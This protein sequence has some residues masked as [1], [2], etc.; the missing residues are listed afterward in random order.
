[1]GVG[2]WSA[3]WAGDQDS[4][5]TIIHEVGSA[6]ATAEAW[7]ELEAAE[8]ATVLHATLSSAKQ[9]VEVRGPK[10]ERSLWHVTIEWAPFCMAIPA[11]GG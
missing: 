7:V 10:G 3:R 6:E 9:M 2:V 11:G 8:T 4:P 1:M 5:F